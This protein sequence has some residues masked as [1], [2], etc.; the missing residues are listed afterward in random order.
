MEMRPYAIRSILAASDLTEASDEVLRAAASLAAQAGAE[1]HVLHS[2]DFQPLPYTNGTPTGDG[3]PERIRA[4]EQ[5]LDDQ[6]HRSVRPELNIASRQVVIYV[7]YKAILERAT[8]VSADLVVLGPHRKRPVADQVLGSTADRV[9][10]TAEVPCLVVRA[11]V[12]PPLGRTVV[13]TDLSEPARGALEQALFWAKTF[14][15]APSAEE[16]PPTELR[17]LHVVPQGVGPESSVFDR[18]VVGPALTRE[19]QAAMARAGGAEEVKVSEE[20]IR[21]DPPAAEILRYAKR[22]QAD[23]L[24]L[25]THGHGVLARALVGSVAS[26]VARSAPCSVLLVPPGLD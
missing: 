5:A 2:F 6:I 20:L 11:P 10:R 24:V 23:L 26:A 19:V 4:A 8:Q 12:T 13:P 16:L 9:I 15:K 1:L 3:F 18:T 17:V 14:G 21:G 7:A 22:E 25:G